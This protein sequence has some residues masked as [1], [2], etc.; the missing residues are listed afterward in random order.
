MGRRGL[1]R[2]QLDGGGLRWGGGEATSGGGGES[3]RW[4]AAAGGG[5]G[6]GNGEAGTRGE[7]SEAR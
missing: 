6:I 5:G 1:E 4:P 3:G 7:L 2:A